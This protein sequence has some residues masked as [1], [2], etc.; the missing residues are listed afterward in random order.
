MRKPLETEVIVIRGDMMFF[1]CPMCENLHSVKISDFQSPNNDNGYYV[2]L[3]PSNNNNLDIFHRPSVDSS[4][5]ITGNKSHCHVIIEDGKIT[6][7]GDS[8]VDGRYGDVQYMKMKRAGS[9][10]AEVF[11]ESY[12]DRA[13]MIPY[14]NWGIHK[15]FG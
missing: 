11:R 14:K 1:K 5:H 12:L 13:K 15:V 3:R 2:F 8:S 7:C 4:M 6:I 10:Y 9:K